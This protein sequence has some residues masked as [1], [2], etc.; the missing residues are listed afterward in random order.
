[1]TLN[2]TKASNRTGQQLVMAGSFNL[3]DTTSA[4]GTDIVTLTINA[5]PLG[6]A[7]EINIEM[8]G[9]HTSTQHDV[10][11][12]IAVKSLSGVSFSDM[13]NT[14]NLSI[15]AN[16]NYLWRVNLVEDLGNSDQMDADG[17]SWNGAGTDDGSAIATQSA[18]RNTEVLSDIN[19]MKKEMT[20]R[21]SAKLSNT[22]SSSGDSIINYKVFRVPSG[23]SD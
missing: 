10:Q 8:W 18:Y 16:Q 4:F 2:I 14:T 23:G 19:F 9:K 11:L 21:L 13:L 7:D 6:E 5:E 20:L 12:Q 17:H 1:M 3:Q 15:T 22:T